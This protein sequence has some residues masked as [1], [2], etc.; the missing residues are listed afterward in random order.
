LRLRAL[1]YTVG[2]MF[3]RH[4]SDPDQTTIRAF[5][6]RP[7]TL[8]LTARIETKEYDPRPFRGRLAGTTMVGLRDRLGRRALAAPRA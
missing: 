4:R 7:E 5:R 3:R 1:N 8:A 6:D 2:D